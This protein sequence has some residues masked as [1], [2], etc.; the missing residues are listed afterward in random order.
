MKTP[1]FAESTIEVVVAILLS[2]AALREG[3]DISFWRAFL[4][5]CAIVCAVGTYVRM[6]LHRALG[7]IQKDDSEQSPRSTHQEK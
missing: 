3:L 2:T 7:K 4:I 5:I 1:S 6:D